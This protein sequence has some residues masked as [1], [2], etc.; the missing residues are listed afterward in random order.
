MNEVFENNTALGTI[1]SFVSK[2]RKFLLITLVTILLIVLVFISINF[3]KNVNNEK[4]GIIYSDFISQDISSEEGRLISDKLLTELLNS[5]KKTGYTKIAVINKASFYAQDNQIDEAIKYFEI[6]RDLTS[7]LSGD[8]LLN[9]IANVNLARIYYS[10]KDYEKALEMLKKY[11]S[12]SSGMVYE[13]TGD[14]LSKQ[15]KPDLAKAQYLLA[16]DLY[17]DEVSIDIV[18]MKIANL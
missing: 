9:K 2:N 1:N 13:I 7:G 8:K 14:I 18:S 15:D 5:Y 10:I 3:L 16:K 6:L 12:S 17:T 4:A 11:D